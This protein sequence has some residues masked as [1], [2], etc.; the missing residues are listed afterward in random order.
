VN[1]LVF[2][3]NGRPVTDS[4]T[5]AEAFGKGH[6]KVL[7]DIRELGC[8]EE[9]RL[10]NFGESYYV[11]HQGRKMPRYIMTEQGF[12]LLVMG[13]TGQRAMEFKEKYIAEFH[14]MRERLQTANVVELDERKIRMALLKSAMEHEERLESVEKRIVEIEQKVDEQITLDHGE[15]RALQKAVARRIYELEPNAQCRRELFRQ[16][17]REIKDRWAVASYRDVRRN[18]LQ[19]V[20]RYIDG[21]MPRRVS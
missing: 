2:I 4:L 21:W 5:V 19:Q 18:E 1:Q 8:S 6:D 14:Q 15:Q 3:E 13:Y 7:R 17:H 12:T 20:L 10:A 11:N 9:F 16:L